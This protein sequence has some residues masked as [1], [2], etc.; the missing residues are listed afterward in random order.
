M[1][2]NERKSLKYFKTKIKVNDFGDNS[3]CN[4]AGTIE[5][6]RDVI[7]LALN[8]VTCIKTMLDMGRMHT[9]VHS[10]TRESAD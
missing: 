5:H 7:A 10:A 3:R 9:H 4:I 6:V 8:R 2:I 1:D